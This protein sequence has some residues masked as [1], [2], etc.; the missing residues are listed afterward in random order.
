MA[1]IDKQVQSLPERLKEVYLLRKEEGLS[2]RE[3]AGK[4]NISE[5]TVKNQLGLAVKRMRGALKETL[6]VILLSSMNL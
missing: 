3:I 4:L 6:I 1:A 5:Q 2:I